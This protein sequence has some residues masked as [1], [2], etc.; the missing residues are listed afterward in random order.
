[1][2]KP[3]TSLLLKLTVRNVGCIGPDPVEIAL[4]EVVCL[5]GRNNSGKSTILRAYEL[6]QGSVA[7]DPLMD[8]C[9]WAPDDDPSVIELDVH[10]PEGIGNVDQKWKVDSGDHLVVRSKWEWSPAT[11][12]QKIRTTWDPTAEN[13]AE[14][15]KAGGADN[16]FKSR[17]PQPLRI[18]SL[19]DAAATEQVLLTLALEPF[20]AE[21]AG[22]EGDPESGLSKSV[23]GLVDMVRGL[24][25]AHQERFDAIA[26]DVQ[27]GFAGVFPN[28]GLKLDI[29]MADPPIKLKELL[30]AGSG[31]RVCEGPVETSLGQQGTGARRALFWSMLRV[32]NELKRKAELRESLKK[33]IA[34]KL[35]KERDEAKIAELM[36]QVALIE[37]MEKAP[38]DADDPAFPGYLLL[39]DEPENALHPMAARLAQ[40]HLYDLGADKNWQVMMTTHSPY[41]VNPLEDHTTIVRLERIAGDEG[42]LTHKTYRADRIKF[43]DNEKRQLQA[44]QQMDVG[45]SEVFFGSYPVLVEGDTEHASCLAAAV[46]PEHKL[47]DDVTI[48]RARGKAI[49]PAL[50][51]MLHHFKV[52]FSILHDIDWPYSKTG[53]A[54]AMWGVN[55]SIYAEIKAAREGRL[56]VRHRCSVPDFERYLGYE[57]LGKEKPLEAYLKVANDEALKEKVQGLFQELREGA[58][59]QAFGFDPAGGAN[60]KDFLKGKLQAWAKGAGEADDPRLVGQQDQTD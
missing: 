42:A 57:E 21:M 33:P 18:G 58:D 1:M 15:G 46:E 23:R 49:L 28:L 40:R 27:K 12:Y 45:F 24:A 41:F 13:W 54:A 26:S 52:D 5:V 34:A 48:I 16:V 8:R 19:E 32:H 43:D 2:A 53:K 60:F 37:A 4:D 36:E 39:I 50:I 7:F 56:R 11:S 47:A 29:G 20:V 25:A 59:D 22:Q 31:I 9:R 17:L 44:L 35:K 14:E 3:N 30:K 55:E 10:I 38:E 51:R 6:A